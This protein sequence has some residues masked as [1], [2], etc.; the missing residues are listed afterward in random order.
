[1]FKEVSELCLTQMDDGSP[2]ALAAGSAP[3]ESGVFVLSARFKG[4]AHISATPRRHHVCFQLTP[5]AHFECRIAGKALSHKPEAGS[6]AI[7]PAGADYAA[8]AEVSVDAILVAIEPGQFALAA[9]EG[10]ALDAQLIA[11]FSGCDHELLELARG[12]AHESADGYPNGPLFWNRM[13]APSLTA[14]SFVTL[15]NSKRWCAASWARTYS[16]GSGTMSLPISTSQSRLARLLKLPAAARSTLR[17][18]SP[19]RSA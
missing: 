16:V 10:S 15:Q 6:L 3:G 14:Y 19:D 18:C 8:D 7:C 17:A 2:T 1:M 12:L 11:R 9:A 13:A 5:S 4:G